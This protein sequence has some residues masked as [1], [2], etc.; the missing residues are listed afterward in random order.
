MLH[1]PSDL[2]NKNLP[3]S[4]ANCVPLSN[5]LHV[6]IWV[7]FLFLQVQNSYTCSTPLP[8]MVWCCYQGQVSKHVKVNADYDKQTMSVT[9]GQSSPRWDCVMGSLALPLTSIY[10]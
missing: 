8:T 7:L 6:F 1:L 5:L 10:L 4:L 9:L 2:E 3:L